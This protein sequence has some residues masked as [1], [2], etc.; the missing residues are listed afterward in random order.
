MALFEK[1]DKV[2]S[3]N[4]GPGIIIEV[5]P[6]GRRMQ[7]YIVEFVNGISETVCE[8]E[9]EENCDISDP[10]ER[11]SRGLFSTFLDFSKVNTT[12]KIN[13][14]NN[15][16]ISSLKASKTIFKVYQFK[17]LLKFLNSPNRRILVADDVG[18][19]KTIE[20]GHIMMELRSR[21]E[22][23]NV[24]IV[25]PKSLQ[26][27]WKEELFD[28]F[29][30]SFK[31]YEKQSDLI[32]DLNDRSIQNVR[33]IINY[34][35][36]RE[37]KTDN[38]N[39]DK[40]LYDFFNEKRCRFSLILC[41]EAHKLRNQNATYNGAQAMLELADAVLFLTATPVMISTENL[42]NLLHLLDQ[43]T[44][45]NAQIFDNLL[46]QNKPFIKAIS[47]INHNVPFTLILDNLETATVTTSF[48]NSDDE[49][50]YTDSTSLKSIFGT[51]PIFNEI[52]TL[53]KSNDTY[54]TRSKLQYLLSSMSSMNN[55]FS[56]TRK[57]EVTTDFSQ[58][59]RQ[60]H[61]ELV[62]LYP[63][64]QNEFDC[65]IE[66]Y[67][68]DN[69]YIDEWG[70][71]R[72]TFG[73]KLGLVQRKRQIASSVYAYLNS[74]EDLDAGI[75]VFE[76]ELDSKFERLIEVIEEVFQGPSKKIIVFALFVK[77]LKY[78]KIKLEQAGYKP[79]LIHG[80]VDNRYDILETFKKDSSANILLSSEVGSEGLDL[81]FCNSLVNYDLPWNP[82]VVE[83]RIGRI[84]RFGQKAEKIHIYNFVVAGS[85][86]EDIYDRLLNR[87]GIFKETIGD[88]ETI[89]EAI[90]EKN[91]LAFSSLER[92]LF[93][94]KRTAEENQRKISEVAQAIENEKQ[95]IGRLQS[96]LAETMTNDAYFQDE[97]QKIVNNRSYVTEDE[98]RNYLISI[99]REKLTT[100]E[101][102]EIEPKIFEFKI[103]KFNTRVLY[104]F[105]VQYEPGDPEN[106][107]LFRQFK[108]L[109]DE[110]NKLLVTFNQDI[111]YQNR[112]LF[113]INI[114]HPLIQACLQFNLE[115]HKKE[116][117]T[118]CFKVKDEEHKCAPNGYYLCIYQ[119]T[120][121]KTAL[122]KS[123]SSS[124][125]YPVLMDIDRQQIVEDDA[126]IQY[127]YSFIQSQAYEGNFEEKDIDADFV[128]AMREEFTYH[129]KNLV[130]S[131]RKDLLNKHRSEQLRNARQTEDYYNTF[132]EKERTFIE[133]K[134]YEKL[135]I[136]DSNLLRNIDNTIRL[137]EG[138][139]KARINEKE[140]K[141]N[142]INADPKI[143]IS[144]EIIALCL[145]KIK[146]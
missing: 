85:I 21:K 50:I 58:A 142:F 5:L 100:C 43:K 25:C 99:I 82:M 98:L 16:T 2:I 31:I 110:R 121:T 125:L 40:N 106:A 71:E 65:V 103:D 81:Q 54:A 73:K 53:L 104:N 63:N 114:Y 91:G 48:Y 28:K 42:F 26:E 101:L 4:E 113:Y 108:H 127:I 124:K 33:A 80:Q 46:Q 93:T 49:E 90:E 89:L 112:E 69:S 11:C 61:R 120:Y 136:S 57:R 9:L 79:L 66:E 18:L 32:F 137:A 140:E 7:T 135:Y 45:Y 67:Y 29:G 22:L 35:K 41:D 3:I 76:D 52:I 34:E 107:M 51:D 59:E 105:L 55:M 72:M 60:P 118:F 116:N 97:I 130:D 131:E 23:N 24:L 102:I 143:L 20:A 10:F 109:L 132:I 77:T 144:K 13:N 128:A 27:K 19:G 139:M 62:R 134:K 70:E 117:C 39:P 83:Q 88:L 86:Q 12:F 78:L 122:G 36:I 56:R 123:H 146:S 6:R 44:F 75:N 8:D 94:T 141:L 111:A 95:E 145:I 92:E 38:Y 47:D 84:D 14:T 96:G 129:M 17:P 68:E 87:I 115:K 15:N 64:E 1:G 119:L 37:N 126:I 74:D 133:S 30:I 138:R